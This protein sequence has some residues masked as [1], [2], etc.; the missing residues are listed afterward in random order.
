MADGLA[1]PQSA[2]RYPAESVE[3]RLLADGRP[4][5]IRPLA[6]SDAELL[7]DFVRGLSTSARYQRFQSGLRELAPDLLE[8][9]LAVDYRGSM[10][11]VALVFEHGRRQIVGEA[12]Y[13][14]ALD[15]AGATD[16]ALAIAD[17][18]QRQGIGRML[19]DRLLRYAARNGIARMQG[20]VLHDNAAMLGLARQF[21]FALRLHPDGAWL[22]RVEKTLGPLAI[23]A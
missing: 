19:F 7:Q 1:L 11:F 5:L 21:G 10:A 12:R 15:V 20:D 2:R 6:A 13:A 4:L 8:R 22:T 17:A 14:P 3:I 16:F 18:W 23:A 9:L